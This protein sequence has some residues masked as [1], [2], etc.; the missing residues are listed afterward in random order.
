M[1]DLMCLQQAYKRRKITEIKQISRGT[2]PADAITKSKP[3]LVLKLLVDT[4]KLDLQVI[5]WVEQDQ[6]EFTE[7]ILLY[8]LGL[9]LD[10]VYRG[11]T[12]CNLAYRHSIHFAIFQSMPSV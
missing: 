4:N 7:Q 10:L 3:Y 1:I 9:S 11:D 5:E 2:N 8:G 12:G 6:I